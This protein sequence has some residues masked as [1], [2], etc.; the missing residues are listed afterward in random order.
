MSE[1]TVTV[2]TVKKSIEV[3]LPPERAYEVFFAE[4]GTWWP[5]ATHS[6]GL[7]RALSV[8]GGAAAGDELLETLIDGTTSVWGSVVESDPPRSATLSW[9][10]GRPADEATRLE[11]TFTESGDGGT[12]VE[13]V[14]SGWE[15]W[16]DGATQA[17]GYNE[18]WDI[19][20]AHYVRSS[21]ISSSRS[22]QQ[23]E[24]L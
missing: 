10:A 4:I 12:L 19:V 7:E 18:G 6:V 23:S 9:H 20:L 1:T 17:A 11:L 5:L 13:L 2:A 21:W 14:H 22:A 24:T 15:R 16:A 3:P 8:S